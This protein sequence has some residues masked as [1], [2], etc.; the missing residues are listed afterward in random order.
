MTQVQRSHFGRMWLIKT[1]IFAIVLLGLG[2]WGAIDAWIVYP[3][4]GKRHAEWAKW[5]Y[6][7]AAANAG[8]ISTGASVAD[9]IAEYARLQSAETFRTLNRDANDPLSPRQSQAVMELARLTWLRSLDRV[10]MLKPEHTQIADPRRELDT[11]SATW[12]PK[13]APKSLNRWDIPVQYLFVLIGIPGG[14]A[15][16]IL[17]LRVKARVYTWSADNLTLTLPN[18]A[19]I[20]PADLAEV[21]KRRWDKFIVFLKIKPGHATLGGQEIK[22]DLY[23]HHPVEEWVLAM[24]RAA[25]PAPPAETPDTR[26]PESANAGSE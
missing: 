8:M 17:I 1:T 26:H 7:D 15:M 24:E 6:L 23:R 11:L 25:F 18:G 4:A 20:T 9:P 2:V 19:S 14:V 22:I 13:S 12:Q 10:A 21:D 16:L 5:K 3:N